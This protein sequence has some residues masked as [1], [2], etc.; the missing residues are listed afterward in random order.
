MAGAQFDR[1]PHGISGAPLSFGEVALIKNEIQIDLLHEFSEHLE[2]GLTYQFEDISNFQG[3]SGVD[4]HNHLGM[5]ETV[6][7]F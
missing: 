3:S 7:R 5:V 6:F 1:E 2:I 4:S